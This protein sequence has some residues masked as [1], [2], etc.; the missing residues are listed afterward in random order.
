[1]EQ[2]IK[3]YVITVGIVNRLRVLLYSNIIIGKPNTYNEHFAIKLNL[4]Q[5]FTCLFFGF[6]RLSFTTIQ[7]TITLYL[8]TSFK[9]QHRVCAKACKDKNDFADFHAMC[10]AE[11][12]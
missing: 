1:M 4:W 9:V 10:D 2:E 11:Q 6:V 3:Q 12:L 5:R 8:E 7:N